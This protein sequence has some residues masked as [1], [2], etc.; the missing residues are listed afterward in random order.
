MTYDELL[1]YTYNSC[2]AAGKVVE[3]IELIKGQKRNQAFDFE[4]NTVEGECLLYLEL[5]YRSRVNA[6]VF[7]WYEC[8][9][10]EIL[11]AVL[12][13]IHS[14]D[15][16][17]ELRTLMTEMNDA[18]VSLWK[19]MRV[20]EIVAALIADE[21]KQVGV[22]IT[23]SPDSVIWPDG[24]ITKKTSEGKKKKKAPAAASKHG[25]FGIIVNEFGKKSSTLSEPSK[26]N[27][28]ATAT[29]VVTASVEQDDKAKKVRRGKLLQMRIL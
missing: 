21:L 3:I 29:T 27:Q 13:N 26:K 11:G 19:Q 15:L 17:H 6:S 18:K 5:N 25:L 28:I 7:P 4:Y 12:F 9:S 20:V 14:T 24:T 8:M 2:H 23:V 16:S 22:K 1:K 10:L